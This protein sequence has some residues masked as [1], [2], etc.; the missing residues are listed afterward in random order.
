MPLLS[1]IGA[2]AARAFGFLKSLFAGYAVDNSLR[3][4][5]GSSDSLT[6]TPASSGNRRTYT[7]STWL[8]R[9]KLSTAEQFIGASTTNF[10][11]IGFD[12]TDKIRFYIF[13][14]PNSTVRVSTQVF[15]DV[16][17]WYHIVI[18]V[19]T[20]NATDQNRCR[21]YV[22]GTEIT[23]WTTNNSITQ[24]LDTS[25]NQNV[26]QYIGAHGYA[27][28]PEYFNGYMSEV[29]MIDGQQLTPSSFG[30]TDEDTGIWKPIPYTGT[31]GTNGFYLEFKDSSALGDDTSGNGNDFTVNNLTSID[32]T[33][34][35]CTNNFN[36]LNPLIPLGSN[37]SAPTE[38]NLSLSQS[39]TGNTGF[40][41][42]TI[43]PS[44]GKWYFE[45][46]TT[47]VSTSDRTYIAIANFES[48]TGT[49]SIESGDYK[50]I[51]V[52]TGT[53]GRIA[54]TDGASTTEFDVAGYVP[55][56]NDIM[57]FAVDMDNSRV[58]IG[59]NGTWF[60]TTADS[61]GD[62]ATAT[63]FF[64]PVLGN[65]FAVGATHGAGTSVSATNLYNFGNPP[66]TISSGNTD[67]AG[68]GN[69]EYAVPSGYYSLCTK[70]LAN[71]G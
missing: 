16:S 3:F 52:S 65:G 37:F 13:N 30:E 59:K 70:N 47:V 10:D 51:S 39:G 26:I 1:T 35:T 12:S 49:S 19:D 31:Y 69:F 21:I 23:A 41:A 27:P 20:T 24:N 25:F 63:G 71:F 17:A 55:V 56:A 66:F 5:R 67:G 58:Y 28:D 60:T 9:T 53:Y 34:D 14:N 44:A 54:V 11:T 15:R 61:G 40:Y 8:K 7:I 33:T 18:A 48:V 6:R 22:N 2:A 46:K 38:G 4:N 64:S 57:I 42:S 32:Q 62:P 45:V 29:Y 36:T 50:G 43:I 68:F